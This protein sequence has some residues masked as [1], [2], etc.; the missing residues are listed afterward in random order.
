MIYEDKIQYIDDL[1]E[2]IKL[3]MNNIIEN[4]SHNLQLKIQ[5]LDLLSPLKILQRGYSIC[6]NEQGELI[7]TKKQVK[8]NDLINVKLNDGNI[9]TK[10]VEETK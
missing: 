9:K 7:K 2:K 6:F 1:K 10:V 5:K 8:V 3:Y 4:K